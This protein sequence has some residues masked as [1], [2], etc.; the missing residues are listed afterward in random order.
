MEMD[1]ALTDYYSVRALIQR[2][3]NGRHD[4][5]LVEYLPARL[6]G[7]NFGSFRCCR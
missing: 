7:V 6:V 2:A 5:L 1:E 3:E 4:G